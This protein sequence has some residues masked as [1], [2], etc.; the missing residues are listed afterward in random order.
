MYLVVV[1]MC[2]FKGGTGGGKLYPAE[3]TARLAAQ[4]AAWLEQAQ[5]SGLFPTSLE[6]RKQSFHIRHESD[7]L[8]DF[9]PDQD[10]GEKIAFRLVVKNR[11][12]VFFMTYFSKKRDVKIEMLK[13]RW[14]S[15]IAMRVLHKLSIVQNDSKNF[16]HRF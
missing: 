13:M 4:L 12:H 14:M 16:K 5:E 8:H 2:D 11:V 1:R 6:S 7:I 9:G 15:C 3:R 10:L